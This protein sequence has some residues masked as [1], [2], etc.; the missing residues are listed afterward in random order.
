VSFDPKSQDKVKFDRSALSEKMNATKSADEARFEEIS[1][2]APGSEVP[3][4]STTS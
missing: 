1:K 2:A 4:S 3:P